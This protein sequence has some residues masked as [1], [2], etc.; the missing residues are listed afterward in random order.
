MSTHLNLLLIWACFHLVLPNKLKI[1]TVATFSWNHCSCLFK[2]CS[3]HALLR[4]GSNLLSDSRGCSIK[5]STLLRNLLHI[6]HTVGVALIPPG[7]QYSA[8]PHGSQHLSCWI[9]VAAFREDSTCQTLCLWGDLTQMRFWLR[10]HEYK[11]WMCVFW[12]RGWGLIQSIGNA[13]M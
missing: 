1:I 8:D 12:G 7:S 4:M 3:Q 2:R 10:C 6:G 11:L 13:A 9:A 5:R